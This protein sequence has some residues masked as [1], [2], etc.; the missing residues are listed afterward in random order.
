MFKPN[1]LYHKTGRRFRIGIFFVYDR[2]PRVFAKRVVE[3][4]WALYADRVGTGYILI[5]LNGH[6]G[7]KPVA[8]HQKGGFSSSV[9]GFVSAALDPTG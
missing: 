5:V 2:T 3:S 6:D 4:D 9:V 1:S 8:I 7:V